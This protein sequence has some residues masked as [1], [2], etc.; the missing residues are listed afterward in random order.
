[1]TEEDVV[2]ANILAQE[3]KELA[4]S[5]EELIKF[6]HILDAELNVMEMN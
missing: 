1:M 3:L 6:E 4:E 2:I 5:E